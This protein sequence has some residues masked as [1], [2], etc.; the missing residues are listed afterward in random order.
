MENKLLSEYDFI[1]KNYDVKSIDDIILD[2]ELFYQDYKFLYI[3]DTYDIVENYLP[4]TE[5]ELFAGINI[6][7]QAQ[8]FICYDYF[9]GRF[10]RTNTILLDEYRIEL[11]AAKNKLFKHLKDAE[12]VLDNIKQLKKETIGF[13]TNSEKTV[14]FFKE[15]FEIL[16]LLL[17]LDSK[18]ENIIEEFF[19]FLKD[20]LCVNEIGLRDKEVGDEVYKIFADAQPSKISIDVF[21][22]YVFENRYRLLSTNK[23]DERTIFLENT[24]RDIKVIDRVIKI[25]DQL[26]E[27]GYLKCFAIYLSSANKT[28]D[29][30]KCFKH[31]SSHKT[32]RSFHRNIYQYFLYDRI[33]K[34][35]NTKESRVDALDV[36]NHLKQLLLKV[37]E[38]QKTTSHSSDFD[39]PEKI[40]GNIKKIF[41]EESSSLDNHFLIPIF[42]K[43]KF[44]D[45]NNI[46]SNDDSTTFKNPMIEIIE[47][48]DLKR[49]EYNN[50]LFNLSFSL[51]QLNQTFIAANNILNI[52]NFEQEYKYGK[53]IIRNPYQHLPNLLLIGSD[54]NSIIKER[55][56]SFLDVNIEIIHSN[57]SDVLLCFNAVFEELAKDVNNTLDQKILKSILIPYLNLLA[58]NKIIQSQ[59]SN[60]SYEEN[61]IIDLEKNRKILE[62]NNLKISAE[63]ESFLEITSSLNKIATEIIYI[64]IWLYRRNNDLDKAIELGLDLITKVSSNDPRVYQGV[65]LAYISKFYECKEVTDNSMLSERKI[66]LDNS[67]RFLKLAQVSYKTLLNE[68][69]NPNEQGIVLKNLI[70]VLN[71]SADV[72]VRKYE[73]SERKDDSLIMVARSYI[74]DIK[75][76]FDTIHLVYDNYPTYSVTELEIEYYEALIL[77]EL[78]QKSRA[79]NK[80]LN[81]MNRKNNL[82]KIPKVANFIDSR[83]LE[84][85]EKIEH[86]S[87]SFF[88]QQISKRK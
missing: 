19:A 85:I 61:I 31:K 16:L 29:I 86:L 65:A 58:Q 74:E 76:F 18:K 41:S 46:F 66:L 47:E 42:E 75:I 39:T 68:I 21:S 79:Y 50:K 78:D 34:E 8:K 88:S 15:N 3:I 35:F 44:K 63:S 32:S 54:F 17:I 20:R 53:D 6:H 80:I 87:L 57:K 70:A 77:I 26:N 30:L 27:K 14:A 36:L 23:L 62:I 56:Y 73:L 51:S 45:K 7:F 22:D 11:L 28:N 40:F 25:N 33:K 24:F 49:K 72:S 52:Q 48:I 59:N 9:F 84:I 71:S 5:V 83:F 81:A 1:L 82:Q 12:K 38:R 64:L 67:L 69:S 2:I 43:Y 37:S 4:Y 13:N 60:N 10:N 55:L